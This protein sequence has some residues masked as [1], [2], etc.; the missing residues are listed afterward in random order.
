M[1]NWLICC[2]LAAVGT[3]QAQTQAPTVRF[4]ANLGYSAGGD[5]LASGNYVSG[6]SYSIN[7]GKGVTLAVGADFRVADKVTLQATVGHHQD[8]T[9]ASNGEIA[10]KRTPVELLGFYEMNENFRL[11]G[12]LRK[13]QNAEVTATGAAAGISAAGSYESTLGAVLE[14]QYFFNSLR[15]NAAEHK[16]LWGVGVR[17]V[18][19]SFKQANS[20]AGSKNGSHLAVS[21]LFY[22]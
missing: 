7:A 3:A 20:T 13:A 21:F 1:K 10:F 19:E 17:F 15:Y 22:Y 2:M 11:G 16:A 9:N 14:G 8:S 6:A 12:G 4:L 5:T 18:N